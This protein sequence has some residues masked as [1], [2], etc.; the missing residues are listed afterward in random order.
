MHPKFNLLYQ[1]LYIEEVDLLYLA[2][3]LKLL[4]SHSN[5]QSVIIINLVL[6][7]VVSPALS[8]DKQTRLL[9]GDLTGV[10][11]A[12]Y[13]GSIALA[14]GCIHRRWNIIFSLSLSL[15]L[16]RFFP[17]NHFYYSYTIDN[18]QFICLSCIAEK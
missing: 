10:T 14:I 7:S 16:D 1:K 12:N 6:F 11:D 2:A 18:F 15:W 17:F 5:I 9:L 13:A 8:G 4:I 3:L